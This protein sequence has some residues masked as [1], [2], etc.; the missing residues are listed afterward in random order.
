MIYLVRF[1]HVLIASIVGFIFASIMHTQAVLAK[2]TEIEIFISMADR[3]RST[4]QDL[5][6]LAPSY[7]VIIVIV[8]LLSFSVAGLVN[9]KLAMPINIIYPA[10]GGTGFLLML[11]AMQPILDV[12]LIAGARGLSGLTL[13]VSAGVLAGICFAILAK[14]R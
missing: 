1:M 2:L 14:R 3:I 10:A 6:G 13:Q 11:L 5:I 12:T 7:G 4:W 8:L 9:K